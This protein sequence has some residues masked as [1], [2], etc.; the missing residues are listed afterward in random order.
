[1]SIIKYPE[2][3]WSIPVLFSNDEYILSVSR[4]MKRLGL[5]NPLTYTYGMVPSLWTGGRHS[6]VRTQDKKIISHVLE[7][8]IEAGSIPTFTMSRYDIEESE[9]ND[10]FCNWLLDFGVAHGCNF[11]MTSDLLYNHIKSRY[12]EA[13][14]VASVL[15]PIYELDKQSLSETDFYNMLLDKFDRVV[16]RPEY[17][18]DTLLKDY[19]K[20]SD[21]SKIEV[22]VNQVCV[23]NCKVAIEEH[24]SIPKADWSEFNNEKFEVKTVCPRSILEKNK[25]KRVHLDYPT[26]MFTEEQINNIVYNIGIKNLKLQGRNYRKFDTTTMI[27]NYIF[28]NIGEFQNISPLIWGTSEKIKETGVLVV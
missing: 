5:P 11:I 27:N 12:P 8:V 2:V 13:K 3:K 16:V 21:L 10:E 14:C 26:L 17:S 9:L 28:E 1:M 18:L 4:V 15:K 24:L 6:S 19:D 20:L 22:L 7:K 25:S 23:P